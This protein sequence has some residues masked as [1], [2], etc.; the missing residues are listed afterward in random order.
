[1]GVPAELLALELLAQPELADEL[2]VAL[3]VRALQVI[4]KAAA[5]ADEHEQPATRVMILLMDAEVL[6]QLVDS[7]G[8]H[9]DLNLGRAGVLRPVAEFL[10]QLALSFCG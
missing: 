1:L 4:E 2:A 10:D 8:E 6:G 5:A 3:E 9:R 7:I